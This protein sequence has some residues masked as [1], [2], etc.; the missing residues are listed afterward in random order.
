MSRP[1]AAVVLSLV[2]AGPGFAGAQ[3]PA[4]SKAAPSISS[5]YTPLSGCRDVAH[6]ADGE[7]WVEN[8]CKGYGGIPVWVTY[9]DSAR[10]YLGFGPK[11]NVSGMF[12][13]ERD[14]AWPLEWRG[15][16][17]RGAFVPFAVI[18]R[19]FQADG[20][21]Q[22]PLVVFRLRP[23]GTSCIV[24]STE[25]STEAARRIADATLDR[26]ECEQEP[27]LPDS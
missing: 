6:G 23:D 8:R 16:N 2:V 24:G 5:R 10:S 20:S 26:F 11:Q 12:H 18:L 17:A 22:K 13:L 14:H 27:H 9:V 3:S 1:V 19:V 15:R 4:G 7:D 21:G 25:G